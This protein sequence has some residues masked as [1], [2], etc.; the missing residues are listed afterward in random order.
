RSR[1]TDLE[2]FNHAAN[3][4]RRRTTHPIHTPVLELQGPGDAKSWPSQQPSA[5]LRPPHPTHAPTGAPMSP[6]APPRSPAHAALY[7]PPQQPVYE[8]LRRWTD[9]AGTTQRH[10]R[11][12]NTS[13]VAA[14]VR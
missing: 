3:P 11:T 6:I 7:W 8:Q 14:P 13:A 5:R 12:E 10:H 9:A 1:A 2:I 4:N